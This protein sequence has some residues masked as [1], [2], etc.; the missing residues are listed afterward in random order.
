M[1]R[2]EKIRNEVNNNK[3]KVLHFKFNGSRG[4]IDEYEGVITDTFNGIFLVK[5]ND[6]N[7]V[8]SYSYT[9]V[10]IENLIFEDK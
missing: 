5:V 6:T 9:D 2:L 4:Q 10:L 8:K 3:G 1:I 7:R